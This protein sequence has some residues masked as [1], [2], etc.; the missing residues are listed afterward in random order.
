MNSSKSVAIILPTFNEGKSI[1]DTLS[2]IENSLVSVNNYIFKIF[3]AEDGSSDNTRSEVQR[4][5]SK[6]KIQT[7]LAGESA[8]LGY[9]RGVQRAISECYED[10]LVFLDSDGQY[11]PD[12]IKVLLS[13]LEDKTVVVGVRTPRNDSKLRII[14]S[15]LFG[16]VYKLLFKIYL[17]D[18]SSPFIAV[19]KK[20][21]EFII[22][23]EIKLDYFAS[24]KKSAFE[25]DG[26]EIEIKNLKNQIK[27]M[28]Q[29]DNLPWVIGYSGGKDSTATTQLVWQSIKELPEEQRTKP[30]FVI[31]TDTLVENPVVAMWVGFSLEKM[32]LEAK[33]QNMPIRPNRLT[34]ELKDRFWVNLI[35]KGYPAPRPRFRWCTSRYRY[36]PL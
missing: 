14:Y 18:P 32:T 6:S 23:T 29:S 3:I 31:S 19:S 36:L 2:E 33:D 28:Y 22:N 16:L 27:E 9:S 8:R 35:G 10:V 34:P 13:N 20:D 26:I 25:P 21:I 5:A 4:F 17:S 11:D 30:I 15:S 1:F 7:E 24:Y 12:Q